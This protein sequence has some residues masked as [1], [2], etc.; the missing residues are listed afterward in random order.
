MEQLQVHSPFHSNTAP[1]CICMLSP[2]PPAIISL[3]HHKYCLDVW[4]PTNCIYD[5][6]KIS[7]FILSPPF[8]PSLFLLD[9]ASKLPSSWHA[10]MC[11]TSVY[12]DIS[13]DEFIQLLYANKLR[14][15]KTAIVCP[16]VF[17]QTPLC[18]VKSSTYPLQCHM[19]MFIHCICELCWSHQ[20][21]LYLHSL[22]YGFEV[23]TMNICH[24]P[25]MGVVRSDCQDGLI[26]RLS[27]WKK[28][29]T[30]SAAGQSGQQ[31]QWGWAGAHYAI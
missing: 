16:K 31:S 18:V 24:W 4:L 28:C 8:S 13:I 17:D 11:R 10:R 2:S 27:V 6:N 21:S 14:W 7:K 30:D 19:I 3:N 26:L 9:E 29:P 12:Y 22:E 20:P 25:C 5:S 1:K 15:L 23:N